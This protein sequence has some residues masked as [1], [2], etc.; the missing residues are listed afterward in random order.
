MHNFKRW[1][2]SRAEPM[3][4]FALH[5]VEHKSIKHVTGRAT[6]M[7][8]SVKRTIVTQLQTIHKRHVSA[9]PILADCLPSGIGTWSALLAIAFFLCI[10]VCACRAVVFRSQPSCTWPYGQPARGKKMLA[11]SIK[12]RPSVVAQQCIDIYSM[13]PESR[14]CRRYLTVGLKPSYKEPPPNCSVP[15]MIAGSLQSNWYEVG[16][17]VEIDW[18]RS[19]A[20][21]VHGCYLPHDGRARVEEQA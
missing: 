7:C 12:S 13:W 18:H 9:I 10:V 4:P 19:M 21:S 3:K 17:H 8:L 20:R 11:V 5:Y 15:F 2:H 16:N 1:V 6:Y 14:L